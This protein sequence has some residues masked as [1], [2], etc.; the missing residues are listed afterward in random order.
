MKHVHE[1]DWNEW[2]L[3]CQAL[4]LGTLVEFEKWWMPKSNGS[5]LERLFI[6]VQIAVAYQFNKLWTA[7]I[8]HLRMPRMANFLVLCS[9]KIVLKTGSSFLWWKDFNGVYHRWHHRNSKVVLKG[10]CLSKF[11][12]RSYLINMFE[13]NITMSRKFGFLRAKYKFC[14]LFENSAS[15]QF[16]ITKQICRQQI[17]GNYFSAHP[18]DLILELH[19][20][21]KTS[22]HLYLWG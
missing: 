18:S 2:L 14:V 1:I 15:I 9:N 10:S 20:N 8:Y 19:W 7:I 5:W 22:S 6:G 12:N 3:S 21:S 11:K 13:D 16:W 4:P 17:L